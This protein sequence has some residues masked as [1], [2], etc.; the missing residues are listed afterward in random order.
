MTNAMLAAAV[1]VVS[2]LLVSAWIVGW[3]IEKLMGW[4]DSVT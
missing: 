1:V 3:A 2:P 4:E